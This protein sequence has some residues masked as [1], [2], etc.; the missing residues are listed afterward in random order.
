MPTS[1]GRCAG[2]ASHTSANGG[3]ASCNAA[4]AP[5]PEAERERRWPP[6]RCVAPHRAAP[7][8]GLWR[9]AHRK[10][11]TAVSAPSA[12]RSAPTRT[13]STAPRAAPHRIPHRITLRA[14]NTHGAAHSTPAQCAN[15][16]RE[17]RPPPLR[18]SALRRT[19]LTHLL[20]GNAL[21]P[22]P[23]QCAN[24]NREYGA[25]G[26]GADVP[27]ETSMGRGSGE[28]PPLGLFI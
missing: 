3:A 4:A 11:R 12:P 16:N 26:C 22:P 25:A 1:A 8:R 13:A 21:C 10:R 15:A 14:S 6:S 5:R 18:F 27:V 23:P 9:R 2:D 20:N 7:R 24:A 19:T 28:L 17:Q